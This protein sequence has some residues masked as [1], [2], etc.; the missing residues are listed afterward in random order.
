M[1]RS[2]GG[3]HILKG[4]SPT[5]IPRSAKK[6]PDRNRDVQ[7]F[8]LRLFQFRRFNENGA[9]P[10]I[11]VGVAIAPPFLCSLGPARVRPG[12]RPPTHRRGHLGRHYGG[13]QLQRSQK[14]GEAVAVTRETRAG[15]LVGDVRVLS[16]E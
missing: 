4:N 3:D 7:N 16:T 2:V 8:R 11:Q 15:R 9:E 10:R 13:R 14:A 5:E 12:P 6:S 1:P